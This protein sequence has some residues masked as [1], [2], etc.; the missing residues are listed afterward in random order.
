MEV[1]ED[2]DLAKGIRPQLQT[3]HLPTEP[4]TFLIDRNGVIRER[5]EG[6]YG[7]E[8]LEAAMR[9]IVT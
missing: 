2:N 7:V 4:W 3:Y 5:L 9:S 8:E 6:A 1:Y